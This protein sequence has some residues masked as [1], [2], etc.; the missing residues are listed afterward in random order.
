MRLTPL[1]SGHVMS[2][3]E[4]IFR[5]IDVGEVTA[6]QVILK[7]LKLQMELNFKKYNEIIQKKIES[8]LKEHV[9][10]LYVHCMFIF[11]IYLSVADSLPRF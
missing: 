4:K 1:W 11:I 3:I 10:G 7:Y 8:R 2:H 5:T 6:N 9:E